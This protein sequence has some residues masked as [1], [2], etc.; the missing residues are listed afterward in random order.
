MANELQLLPN[1]DNI[2]GAVSTGYQRQ[3]TNMFTIQTGLDTTEP[4]DNGNGTITIPEGGIVEVNGS[5]FKLTDAVTINKP[6][7]A[8]AYWI[9]VSD[10]GDGTADITPVTRPGVWNPSKQGC[11]RSDGSRTLN[12][13]S[14]G[15][16]QNLIE[17][18]MFSR[19]VKGTFP[20]SLSKGWYYADLASGLGGGGGSDGELF[21]NGGGGVASSFLSKQKILFIDK[22]KNI[23]IK[24]G[25]SGWNGGNGG[26]GGVRAITTPSS[27]IIYGGGGGGG[28]SGGGEASYIK[29]LDMDTGESLGG[30]G[31]SGG[32]GNNPNFFPK[33]Y[34]GGGG[35]GGGQFA[36]SGGSVESSFS[37]PGSSG[38]SLLG[39][40]G[41]DMT[42]GNGGRGGNGGDAFSGVGGGGA[43]GGGGSI[44]YNGNGSNGGAGGNST[45]SYPGGGGGGGMGSHGRWRTDGVSAAG[46]CNI[47]KLEG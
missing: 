1:P 45:D 23:T 31:G 13:V 35:G 32:T 30:N 46:Y 4:F 12:W 16:L 43:G 22:Q 10:N 44:G 34:C 2:P 36:G 41:V 18:V 24:I 11:Y 25:G 14:L 3:N 9:A 6:N 5:L 21:Y 7:Q 40:N 15:N 38:S 27:L 39:S 42:G 33:Y 19:T 17:S 8:A 26:G 29:E 20:L 37:L 47:Y 28:G